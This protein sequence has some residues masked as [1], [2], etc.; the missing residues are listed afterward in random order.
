M[1]FEAM[2]L[3]IAVSA[4]FIGFAGVLAWADFR[5]RQ[6]QPAA[7]APRRRSF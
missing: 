7:P 6:S 2:M 5:S 4:V 3:S 1:S